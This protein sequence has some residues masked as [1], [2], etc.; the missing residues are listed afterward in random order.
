MKGGNEEVS[1]DLAKNYFSYL[2]NEDNNNIYL[3]HLTRSQVPCSRPYMKGSAQKHLKHSSG[4]YCLCCDDSWKVGP[5]K[6]VSFTGLLHCEVP[7]FESDTVTPWH[8][9]THQLDWF[10]HS[11]V[12]F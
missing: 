12:I 4:S 7:T 11:P 8:S 6:I 9:S 3:I 2:K 5:A 1:C 10:S